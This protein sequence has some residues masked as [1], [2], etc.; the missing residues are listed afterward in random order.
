MKL[1]LIALIRNDQWNDATREI[2]ISPDAVW[3]GVTIAD[4]RCLP[5][6]TIFGEVR[7]FLA[8]H[9]PIDGGSYALRCNATKL[10]VLL[11]SFKPDGIVIDPL[12]DTGKEEIIDTGIVVTWLRGEA[13]KGG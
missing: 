3:L 4:V 13:G 1:P 5:L 12:S 8:C 9:P 10:L 2:V 11:E 6:F 7:N